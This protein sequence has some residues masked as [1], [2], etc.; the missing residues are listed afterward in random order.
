MSTAIP[1]TETVVSYA[2]K[3]FYDKIGT[4]NTPIGNLQGFSPSYNR[5]IDRIRQLGGADDTIETL[6]GRTDITI[7]IDRLELY[8]ESLL[9]SLRD[10]HL[11][12]GE[13]GQVNAGLENDVEPFNIMEYVVNPNT[14]VERVISY[15]KCLIQS[16][17]K[18][19]REGTITVVENA[20]V[21]PTSVAVSEL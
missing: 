6:P 1:K 4:T 5:A 8:D 18:T 14:G 21:Q 9:N 3:I 12:S 13:G 17:S 19:I 10:E 11:P 15:Q 16:Y 2:Y 20:V 7:S